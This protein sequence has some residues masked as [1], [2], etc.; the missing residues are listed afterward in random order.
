MKQS[1]KHWLRRAGIAAVSAEHQGVRYIDRVP[2]SALESAI[3][4]LFPDL[5]GL[6][7]IQV[8][9]NDG[10]RVDPIHHFVMHH[11]WSGILVE[12]VPEL[13]RALSRTYY[14]NSRLQLVQAAVDLQSGQ[15]PIFHLRTDLSRQPPDWAWGLAT[16][17]LNQ[18]RGTIRQ[19]G[20]TEEAITST[21]VAT[22]TWSAL[23]ERIPGKRCD[24]LVVDTEG[25]DVTLLRGA[26]LAT[27]R[28]RVVHFEHDLVS[29]EDRLG[30]YREL[31]A[32]GYEIWTDGPDTTAW[33][34]E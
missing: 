34:H 8:G 3:F 18:L 6:V 4:R 26:E 19:L 33:L 29:L 28:P 1:I 27:R 21:E 10:Q 32:A 11:Q 15:R 9:A 16:F 31:M 22:M 23:W 13:F 7:F 24:V 2:R 12:P 20:F 17:D 25:Y 30:F 5:T 14:A